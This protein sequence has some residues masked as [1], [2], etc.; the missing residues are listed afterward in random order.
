M[1]RGKLQLQNDNPTSQLVQDT[2]NNNKFCQVIDNE[3]KMMNWAMKTN[4]H[5]ARKIQKYEHMAISYG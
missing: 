3:K 2:A 1:Q 4:T 5:I